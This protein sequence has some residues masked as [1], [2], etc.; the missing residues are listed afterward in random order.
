M[1]AGLVAALFVA[2]FGFTFSNALF[3]S[4]VSYSKIFMP[5]K[6]Q[7]PK[8]LEASCYD[9]S[10]I[11]E[12]E[13]GESQSLFGGSQTISTAAYVPTE[14]GALLNNSTNMSDKS[15]LIQKELKD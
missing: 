10:D 7:D 1:V 15:A 5:E 11:S 14:R 8:N 9:R 12:S 3:R 2:P 4:V 13:F 6:I